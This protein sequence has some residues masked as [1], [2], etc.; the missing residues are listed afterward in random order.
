MTINEAIVA[1]DGQK[2]NAY[3]ENTK[4]AWI[5]QLDGRI[6]LEVMHGRMVCPCCGQPITTWA[7]YTF[8]EDGDRPLLAAAPYDNLYVLYLMAM[9]D[10]ANREYGNYQN[11]MTMFNT[12]YGEFAAQWQ[13]T[14]LPPSAANYSNVL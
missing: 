6:F 2:P 14:H 13:R 1:V 11:S 5:S 8:P 10:F 9:I 3:D 7:G 12:A 4:A